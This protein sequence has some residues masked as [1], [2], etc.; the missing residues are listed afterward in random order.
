VLEYLG[1]Y[2]HRVALDNRRILNVSGGKVTFQ[3]KQYRSANAHKSRTMTVT[4]DEFIRRFLLHSLPSRVPRI[5]HY[6]LFAGRTKKRNLARCRELLEI[7]V[8][9]LLPC[10]AQIQAAILPIS[11]TFRRCPACLIGI[12]VRIARIAPIQQNSS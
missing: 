3:F 5:R 7:P 10:A 6:G 9:S 11:D 4:A 1:R 8:E 2:T 12:M